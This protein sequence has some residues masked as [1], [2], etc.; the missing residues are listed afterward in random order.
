MKQPIGRA[1][2]RIQVGDI[3]Y[4]YPKLQLVCVVG[5]EWEEKLDKESGIEE[6]DPQDKDE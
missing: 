3:I 6:I 4:W 5:S 1:V 2:E